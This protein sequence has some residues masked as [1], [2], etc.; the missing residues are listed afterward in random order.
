MSHAHAHPKHQ[1]STVADVVTHWAHHYGIP[2]KVALAIA[3]VESG[4]NPHS[5]GDYGTSFGLYQLHQG[6]EL[7]SHSETWAFDPSNNARTAL[8]VVAE[9]RRLHPTWSWGQVAA[10][11]QRPADP[12]GYAQKVNARLGAGGLLSG[13]SSIV[14]SVSNHPMISSAGAFVSGHIMLLAVLLVV[15]LMV[16]K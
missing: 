1:S 5:V 16:R 7:G 15:V 12:V 13:N 14:A 3:Q 4:L 6:G 8:R 11:A 10:A 2:P 9:Q